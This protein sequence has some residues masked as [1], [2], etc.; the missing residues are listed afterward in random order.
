MTSAQNKLPDGTIEITITVPWADVQKSYDAVVEK[1]VAEA[2][3]EGFR[4]GKAPRKLVEEKLDKSKI[5]ESVLRDVIPKIYNQAINDLK[6]RPIITPKVE[7]KEA[8]EGKDWV[9]RVLTCERPT[10][11]LGNYRQA[12]SDLKATKQKKIWVPGQE[13]TP[14]EKEK[15]TKPTLDELL[16]AVFGVVQATLPTILTENEINRLLS[17]L[18]DQT[19]KLGLTVEQ[20]LAST[21]RTADSIR[22]EYEEQAKR[23]LT[24]EFALEEIADK[25]GILVSDDDIET[26][27]KTAKSE[28]ERKAL[29]AQKYYLAS[30]LRRQKTLDFL[31]AI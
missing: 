1:A 23:T 28:D 25:E 30:V 19:K 18:I 3:I 4:K 8:S 10:L 12:V 9:L 11:T 21:R 22:H 27:L 5:Y 15:Q 29:E 7:L 17:E 31:A 14:E 16:K 6:L 20:Y 2:E 26:V 13:P 24:L